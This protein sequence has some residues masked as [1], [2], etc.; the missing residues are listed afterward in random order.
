MNKKGIALPLACS[1]LFLIF[2]ANHSIRLNSENS[3]AENYDE[4]KL[5]NWILTLKL[6]EKK[7]YSQNGEDG[8]I[9]AVFENIGTTNKIYVE[10]G[11]ENCIECNSRYLRYSHFYESFS[12]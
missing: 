10:F 4:L 7:I 6:K 9:E 1:T 12:R 5:M 3:I 11:T 2:L 8:V